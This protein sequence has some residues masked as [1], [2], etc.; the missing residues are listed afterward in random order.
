M[1]KIVLLSIVLVLILC[2]CG[3]QEPAVTV[4]ATT[5]PPVEDKLFAYNASMRLF[6]EEITFEEDS[7]K[8]IKKELFFTED[9]WNTFL[10][11]LEPYEHKLD[12]DTL[13][14]DFLTS[15]ILEIDGKTLLQIDPECNY[16]QYGKNITYM[17]VWKYNDNNAVALYGVFI[18]ASI[19]AY[20]NGFLD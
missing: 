3:K 15:Y 17:F 14:S 10:Q 8:S 5:M 19:V 9:Q 7:V 16:P 12:A 6:H 20:L 11:M 2:S 13:K 1:K 4:P 18:D